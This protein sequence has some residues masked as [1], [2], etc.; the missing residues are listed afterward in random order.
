MS[1]IFFM[2]LIAHYLYLVSCYGFSILSKIEKK[3]KNKIER[4][5]K[6]RSLKNFLF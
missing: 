4:E 1:E 5:E 6:K 2:S 3:N